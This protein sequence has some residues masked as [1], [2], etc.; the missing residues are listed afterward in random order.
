MHGI[1]CISKES[2]LTLSEINSPSKRILIR[3]DGSA[4]IGHGHVVRCLALADCL[5]LIEHCEVIFVMIQSLHCIEQVRQCGYSV[6]HPTDPNLDFQCE[7]TWLPK[8]IEE[9]KPH[10]LVLDVRTKLSVDTVRLIRAK[11][12]LIIN[13]DDISDRRL[14]SDLLFYPPIPQVERL[15]W[16]GFTGRLFS[17]WDWVL[18]KPEITEYHKRSHYKNLDCS[19]IYNNEHEMNI[20]VSMG[21]SDPASLTLMALK[22]LDRLEPN[23][24]ITVVLGKEYPHELELNNFLSYKRKSFKILRNVQNM[25]ML[26]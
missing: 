11:G 23:S 1:I 24:N 12:T 9:Q 22:V 15:S 26:W 6:L 13:I 5:R 2:I 20:L 4:D 3:C 18:L 7:N 21:A 14:A 17:G 8:L 25:L 10:A 19:T 16:N